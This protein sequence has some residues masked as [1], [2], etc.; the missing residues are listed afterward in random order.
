MLQLQNIYIYIYI[1]KIEKTE[2]I[3]ALFPVTSCGIM[4]SY[5][6]KRN[7]IFTQR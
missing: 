6:Y 5:K 7:T 4:H 2:Y 3:H 1:D